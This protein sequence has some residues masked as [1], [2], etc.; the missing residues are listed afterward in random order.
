MATPQ[1]DT[2]KPAEAVVAN[3]RKVTRETRIP[4]NMAVRK[5]QV[6]PLPGF[7]MHWFAARN[8]EAA[9]EAGYVHVKKGETSLNNAGI[10]AD[11]SLSGDTSLDTNISI[12]GT[13]D[14]ASED[15]RQERA[16]L[17]KLPTEW[18]KDDEESLFQRNASIMESIFVGEKLF[19]QEGVKE[20]NDPTTY[21][22]PSRTKALFN[23]G[24]RKVK[25][26]G[27]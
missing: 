2:Q 4:M 13:S 14:V 21:V 19:T 26:I 20:N 15:G 23:R 8:V 1:T 11:R 17:M 6:R 22:D 27:R 25:K 3:P 9:Y 12:V 7:Y 24:P 16:Y 10:G 18:R 5:M